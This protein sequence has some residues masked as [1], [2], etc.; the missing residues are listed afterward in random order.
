MK[1]YY[2][3]CQQIDQQIVQVASNCSGLMFI[4]QNLFTIYVNNFPL[5]AGATL[6]LDPQNANDID[7]SVYSIGWGSN[8]G[9]LNIFKRIYLR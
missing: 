2:Y 7:T 6:V 8:S 1:K 4:N 3:E 5:L 9:N